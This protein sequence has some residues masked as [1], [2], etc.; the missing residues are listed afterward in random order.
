MELHA[1]EVAD[2]PL[3]QHGLARLRPVVG[4]V[5]RADRNAEIDRR[6][7]P[8]EPREDDVRADVGIAW[9]AHAD[10]R[11]F[12]HPTVLYDE[13][14][15]RGRSHRHGVPGLDDLEARGRARDGE[16][17]DDGV[18]VLVGGRGVDGEEVDDRRHGREGLAAVEHEALDAVVLL[19]DGGRGRE[20]PIAADLGLGEA[21]ADDPLLLGEH[22]RHE[23]RPW[24]GH[25]HLFSHRADGEE[26]HVDGERGR[27]VALCEAFL[28][29]A[30]VEEC[31]A[32]AAELFRDRKRGVTGFL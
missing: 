26:V 23:H 32:E 27:G 17:A 24:I 12:R 22:A 11:R 15:A 7:G 16:H 29:E 20:A 28:A 30:E 1:G 2:R 19:T 4:E 13:I 10:H 31:A 3:E 5:S 18:A 25:L 21:A 6:D 8:T 9:L 14:V